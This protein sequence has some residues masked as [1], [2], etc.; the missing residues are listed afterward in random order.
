MTGHAGMAVPS[1]QEAIGWR[2]SIYWPENSTFYDGQVVGLD[3]V[4]GR[5]HVLYDSGDQEHVA[6]ET[7]K[8]RLFSP[9]FLDYMQLHILHV[10]NRGAA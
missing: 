7:V 1:G 2:V 8:V 4:T 6:L 10:S 5:H 9:L 3:N